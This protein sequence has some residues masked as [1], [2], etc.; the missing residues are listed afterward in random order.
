MPRITINVDCETPEEARSV[1]DKI[2]NR[3]DAA[4]VAKKEAPAAA[5]STPAEPETVEIDPNRV[6]SEGMPF[7]PEIHS[8]PEHTNQDGTWRAKRGKAGAEKEARAAFKAS[9]GAIDP[10]AVEEPAAAPVPGMPGVSAAKTEDLPP[11]SLEEVIQK[12]TALF[13]GG[14]IDGPKLTDLYRECSG[15][16]PEESMGVFETNET[17]RRKLWDELSK[18]E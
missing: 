14:R 11:V 7:D 4:P 15:V 6:D 18:Y 12:A 9:G 13:N 16:T 17:A 5:P 3:S 8:S 1:I 2:M 10:P